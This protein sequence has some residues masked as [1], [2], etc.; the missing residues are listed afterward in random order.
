MSKLIYI[1]LFLICFN[2]FSMTGKN[3]SKKV[4]SKYFQEEGK[5]GVSDTNTAL[6]LFAWEQLDSNAEEVVGLL[7]KHVNVLRQASWLIKKLETIGQSAFINVYL[8]GERQGSCHQVECLVKPVADE[9]KDFFPPL[10]E[11]KVSPNSAEENYTAQWVFSQQ[12]QYRYELN[13]K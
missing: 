11:Y 9:T 7:N 2:S 5:F 1:S 4:W 6:A 13:K 10:L 3:E 8:S 12:L